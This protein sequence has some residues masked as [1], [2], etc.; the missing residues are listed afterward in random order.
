MCIPRCRQVDGGILVYG[1]LSLDLAGEMCLDAKAVT[2]TLIPAFTLKVR[3]RAGMNAKLIR[4]GLAMNAEVLKVSLQPELVIVLN[5][6]GNVRG[7]LSLMTHKVKIELEAYVDVLWWNSCCCCGGRLCWPCGFKWHNL[8]TWV[9]YRRYFGNDRT[10]VLLQLG[11]DK[12]ADITPPISGEITCRQTAREQ[13]QISIFGFLDEETELAS[14]LLRIVIWGADGRRGTY[15]DY[16]L[17]PGAESWTGHFTAEDKGFIDACADVCNS[18]GR[19]TR[20]CA[21]TVRWDA[22]PPKVP[23]H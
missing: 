8:V 11:A 2:L 16:L 13:A 5:G 21:P 20:A 7:T 23:L 19:C 17:G 22:S 12:D 4:G 18:A 1:V 15:R 10:S 6:D 3:L 14:T 9:W